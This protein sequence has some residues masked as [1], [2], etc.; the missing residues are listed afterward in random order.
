MLWKTG[1]S[2]TSDS[3]CSGRIL[4]VMTA[5]WLLG[6]AAWSQLG[7][8]GLPKEI[9]RV[10]QRQMSAW[11]EGDLEG[12][13]E[14]YWKSDSLVFVGSSG[15]THGHKATLARYQKSYPTMS[16]MGALSF[17][18]RQWT[19]L[20]PDAG[21]LLGGWHLS[22]NDH[23]DAQGMYTLLWRRIEGQWVIV[24]DHSS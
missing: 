5:I 18:N 7:A 14:G 3:M 21:W 22:K 6:S 4:L 11:N 17:D 19:A 24:A 13:M 8:P 12:F 16:M 2:C 10:M 9:E 15:V 20:G 23:D 1:T